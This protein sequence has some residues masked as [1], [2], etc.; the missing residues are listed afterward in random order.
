MTLICGAIKRHD[1]GGDSVCQ[2]RPG[3]IGDHEDPRVPESWP[4]EKGDEDRDYIT[5]LA[6]INPQRALVC[7]MHYSK[8]A[9]SYIMGKCS[10]ALSLRAAKA[11][12]ESWA[13]TL[14]MEIR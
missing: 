11:L 7:V 6:C 13:A 10:E 12:S 2:F 5:L 3:H 14:K 8:P 9:D 1:V 4:Q